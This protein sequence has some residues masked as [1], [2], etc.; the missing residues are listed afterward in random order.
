MP[1]TLEITEKNAYV[2]G[3]EL[4]LRSTCYPLGFTLHIETNSRHILD[5]AAESWL[6]FLPEFA[7]AAPTHL[8]L[9]EAG[10][11][12]GVMPGPPAFRS[13][14]HLMTIVWNQDN[15]VVCDF[16]SGR[17]AGWVTPEI[18][19]NGPV[20]RRHFLES[21]VMSML[22]QAH[23][24]P[25][26][27]AL[28]KKNGRG[29]LLCGP[30]RAGKST[31][32]FACARA[33]WEFVSDDATFLVRG[34]PGNYAV[35]NP[36]TLSLRE[37]VKHSFTELSARVSSVR[38]GGKREIEVRTHDL[39]I[40]LASGSS[41]DHVV[42][43]DRVQQGDAELEPCDAS[44][45]L[46]CFDGNANFGEDHVREAQRQTYRR[47]LSA[48]LWRMRYCDCED[49]IALLSRLQAGGE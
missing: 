6:H 32:A 33:G 17:A 18:A 29:I 48:G 23:L 9:A 38:P 7:V 28:V 36:H 25:V 5:A 8:S 47:L 10:S 19:R 21:S 35:G 34:Q 26:H 41:I 43:L 16:R 24:A 14:G 44:E 15:Q 31:L 13:H 37:D 30:S 12:D 1:A 39:P 20:L 45:A 22:V 49:A 3:F 27:G 42:F 40:A 11:G 2:S 46:A 4:P